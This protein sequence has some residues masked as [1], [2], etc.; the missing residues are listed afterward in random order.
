MAN[1]PLQSLGQMNKLFGKN[2]RT[3]IVDDIVEI[4]KVEPHC[5][6]KVR[7]LTMALWKLYGAPPIAHH[8]HEWAFKE[9]LA[10]K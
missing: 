8:F 5:V 6:L 9:I 7:P 1:H 3:V 2:P 4:P 10:R